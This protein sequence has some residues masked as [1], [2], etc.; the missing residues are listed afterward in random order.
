MKTQDCLDKPILKTMDIATY[1]SVSEQTVRNLINCGIIKGFQ[2]GGKW[3]SYFVK[4]K[5]FDEFLNNKGLGDSKPSKEDPKTRKYS[6]TPH[7]PERL[8]NIDPHKILNRNENLHEI[9]AHVSPSTFKKINELKRESGS[10]HR[11]RCKFVGSL[12]NDF[13]A[14]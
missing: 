2:L 5:D 11:S 7:D 13:Y 8:L 10:S 12:L 4:K 6:K 9:K 14:D 3:G 1:L